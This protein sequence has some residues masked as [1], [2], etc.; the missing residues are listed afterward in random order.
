M[1][2]SVVVVVHTKIDRSLVLGVIVTGECCRK[3]RNGKKLTHFLGRRQGQ[4][5]PQ[6][7]CFH[8]PRLSATPSNAVCCLTAH[9]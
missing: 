1:I 2:G 6:V 7:L 9:A 4:R 5:T 8:W 3:I